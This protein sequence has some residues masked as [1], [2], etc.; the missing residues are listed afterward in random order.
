MVYLNGEF[1]NGFNSIMNQNTVVHTLNSLNPLNQ[2]TSQAVYFDPNTQFFQQ[3]NPIQPFNQDSQIC[4]PQSS[5]INGSTYGSINESLISKSFNG[6]VSTMNQQKDV[7][8]VDNENL[9][10]SH[11]FSRSSTSPNEIC[12]SPRSFKNSSSCTVELE[13]QNQTTKTEETKLN[14][15]SDYAHQ[16]SLLSLLNLDPTE[17]STSTINNL[18]FS[19]GP[20]SPIGHSP[21]SGPATNFTGSRLQASNNF[22]GSNLSDDQ[23]SFN[24]G[25]ASSAYHR[26]QYTESETASSGAPMDSQ[27]QQL[28]LNNAQIGAIMG[29]KGSIIRQIRNMSCAQVKISS[30]SER[31]EDLR[32]C[33]VSGNYQNVQ[34]A[35]KLIRQRLNTLVDAP[36]PI[37]QSK[38]VG[39]SHFQQMQQQNIQQNNQQYSNYPVNYANGSNSL[40]FYNTSAPNNIRAPTSSNNWLNSNGP[41][42]NYQSVSNQS[43]SIN[44]LNQNNMHHSSQYIGNDN[45]NYSNN[46]ALN[47][48]SSGNRPFQMTNQLNHNHDSQND[49]TFFSNTTKKVPVAQLRNT[50]TRNNADYAKLYNATY[51]TAPT[52]NNQPF[53]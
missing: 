28:Y 14:D 4:V 40:G 7:S 19:H 15:F 45:R 10:S 48:N 53:V 18:L 16:L 3:S 2:S 38:I 30:I 41:S 11:D 42:S 32:L 26:S 25:D 27:V 33:V 39:P 44:T 52:T 50:T 20:D 17:Q 5:S 1:Y 24:S 21:R 51:Q 47:Y 12:G 23:Y 36:P 49:K 8:L 46:T 37:Q 22:G 43:F 13:N 31:P 34:I 6:S 9:T 29:E 35:L